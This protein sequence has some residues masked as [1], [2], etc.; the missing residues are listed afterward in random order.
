MKNKH[1]KV[2]GLVGLAIIG[3]LAL[4]RLY[5]QKQGKE[6]VDKGLTEATP[7]N[8]LTITVDGESK[9]VKTVY[10]Y[11]GKTYTKQVVGPMIKSRPIEITKAEF[12]DAYQKFLL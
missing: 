9:D 5:N 2:I 1:L 7:E 11:N 10:I 4:N 8:P 3:M 6:L 12:D